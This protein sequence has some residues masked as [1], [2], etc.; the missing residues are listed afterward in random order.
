VRPSQLASADEA[1][2]AAFLDHVEAVVNYQRPPL[3]R[4]E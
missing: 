3:K 2:I 1:E 4:P